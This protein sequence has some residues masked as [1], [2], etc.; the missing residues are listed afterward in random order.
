MLAE[1]TREFRAEQLGDG[2][3]RELDGL[4]D[5]V[6]G[7]TG[8]GMTEWAKRMAG[9]VLY[10]YRGGFYTVSELSRETGIHKS[11]LYFRLKTM[12]AEEAVTMWSPGA[13]KT[14]SIPFL[15]RNYGLLEL[16]RETGISKSTLRNRLKTMTAEEAVALGSP[17][18][19]KPLEIPF[20][21]RNHTLR[22]LSRE[23]GIHPS[24]FRGRLKKMTAE[25]AVAMGP[26]RKGNTRTDRPSPAPD[27][28]P[29]EPTP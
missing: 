26:P 22:E 14:R 2:A 9:G 1:V 12:T 18:T 8:G 21:G 5:Q 27:S 3:G 13:K 20:L 11:T 7:M 25:E 15:G 19:N 24:V 16:S 4:A 6:H 29:P 28:P 17:G 10:E 23:T